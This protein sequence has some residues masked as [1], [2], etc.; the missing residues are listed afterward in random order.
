[1]K[2]RTLF[3]CFVLAAFLSHAQ[4]LKLPTS[5]DVKKAEQSV[6]TEA[7]KT[8]SQANIGSLIG[9]LTGNISDNAF[10]DKFKKSKGDFIT[11]T[12]KITDGAGASTALQSLQAGLL[13]TAMDAGWGK[14]K[15]KWVKD[16]KTANTVKSVAGVAGTL[17]SNINDSFFKGTWAQARPAWQA[18]LGALAK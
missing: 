1:M 8:T 4:D 2:T 13:P 5:N 7:A 17:E 10:T 15:D 14:V 11:K 9:Q 18:A 12:N 6:K 16:A 3:I